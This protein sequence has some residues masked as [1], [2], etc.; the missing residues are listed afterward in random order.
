MRELIGYLLRFSLHL[1]QAGL[2]VPA[3]LFQPASPSSAA[4]A[5]TSDAPKRPPDRGRLNP[6]SFVVLGE[7]LAAGM[8]NFSLARD[9]QENCFPAQMARQMG[10]QF[11]QR[12]IEPPGIGS[13]V[14][15][16]ELPVI[17]PSPLQTTVIDAIPPE[18]V[19]NLSVPG[20]TVHDAVNLRPA[21]PLVDQR[22]WKQT[23]ANL[24][25]G[26]GDIAYGK[27]GPLPTPLEYAVACCP[28]LGLVELGFAE[29]LEAAIA[30]DAGRLPAPGAFAKDYTEIVRKLRAAGA[31]VLVLT[32]PDPFDTAHFSNIEAAASI[33]KVDPPVLRDLWHLPADALITAA[34]LN[35][36]GFQMFG[37]RIEP[38]PPGSIVAPD[39]AN[40]IR[41]RVRELNGLVGRIAQSDGAI[42]YDLAGFL[43]RVRESAISF[44]P[45]TLTANYLGGFYSLNGYYPGATGHA[46]IASDILALLN[47]RYGAAFAPVDIAEV[48]ASDPV[49][50]YKP[51]G[52]PN[53]TAEALRPLVGRAA[54]ASA[55][56]S[57]RPSKQTDSPRTP[58]RLP[59]GLEQV[60]PLNKA[61]SY[62]GD[63]ISAL[64]CQTPQTIQFGSGG[65]L[66]F[67]GLAMV[68][69]HLSGSIRIKFT[70]PVNGLTRFQVSLEGGF[71]GD[72]E[73]LT[74]PTFFKMAFRRNRVSEVPGTISAG[75]LN[76]ETGEVDTS[77]GS[78][79]IFALYGSTALD[80]LISVNPTF[81]LPPKAPLSFPGQYGSA[82][83]SFEQRADGKLDFNFVGSTFV[84]L[85]NG[86]AWPLNFTG[87]ARQFATIPANGTV[88]HPHLAL[89]TRE[90]HDDEEPTDDTAATIPVNTLHE[91]TLFAPISSFGDVFTLNAPQLGGPATGRSRLLGRVQIQFGPR[92]GNTVPIAVSTAT[93]GGLLAPMDPTPVAQLFPGR[94]TPGPEGFYE[95]LRFPLRTYSLND[96][97]IIDDPFE[98]SVGALDWRSGHSVHP[99]LHRGFINQDLIFALFRVEPRTP[100]NSFLFRGNAELRN[101]RA[102]FPIFQF[103]G[104]V[105]IP[106]PQGFLFPDPN[107]AT[108]FQIG[109]DS[110]L[111]PYLWLWALLPSGSGDV[112]K[113]GGGEFVSSRFERFSYRFRVSNRPDVHRPEFEYE[114]FSQQCKFR[115]HSMSWVSF[116]NSHTDPAAPEEI[117]TI[118]F[119][120]FGVWSKNGVE[121]VEV[122]AVQISTSAKVPYVGIQIG[123]GDVSNA[124]TP[125]PADTYPVRPPEPGGYECC[126]GLSSRPVAPA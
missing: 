82:C 72:D 99:V 106:Y 12:L 75:T 95:N 44:G 113:T 56:R 5:T 84:P 119:T 110:S 115:M 2:R 122:A 43:E 61:L 103:Y 83:V 64:N 34:G 52:G 49:A 91:Y 121:R 107:L 16:T 28:T 9:T 120:G 1:V 101:G 32:I 98:I 8:G 93:A 54:P 70:P 67:G 45:G 118:T 15:F 58:L 27:P 108:G 14:G 124:N 7:G 96:L 18:R 63:G 25:L 6:S 46:L 60:L 92:C 40:E 65:N 100:Q 62:F 30:G 51:A 11:R 111:D 123:L 4:G 109:A 77:P 81:P 126:V 89:S 20:L 97:A 80:A 36:I 31:E 90:T 26:I 10:V 85:G 125:M 114:N 66:L 29:A 71:T 47:R 79:S 23:A 102:G 41:L 104:Q 21:Q 78:L 112:V 3:A 22:D 76:L 88:M 13:A 74:A 24:I 17:V 50:A 87:P 69:S 55:A 38:L 48:R 94:L 73:V 86:I 105:H 117:D 35:E 42:V 53:W 39:S 33:V 59:P 19:S 37:E 116:G 57:V 68:D